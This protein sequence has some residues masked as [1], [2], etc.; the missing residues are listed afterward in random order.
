MAKKM[1]CF[2]LIFLI[3]TFITFHYPA[4]SGV[5]TL[6]VE[7]EEGESSSSEVSTLEVEGEFS[8]TV[9]NLDQSEP[10]PE[11]AE[12]PRPTKKSPNKN[13][14]EDKNEKEEGK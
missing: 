4:Y 10:E 11:K 6:E 1:I 8:G 14:E 12:T 13:Q 5:S 9:I 3:G 7:G 2:L